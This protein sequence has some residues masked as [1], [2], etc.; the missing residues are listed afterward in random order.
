MTGAS[1]YIASWIVK[2]LLAR[3]Y[4][5]RGTV[6]DTGERPPSRSALHLPPISPPPRGS[7]LGIPYRNWRDALCDLCDDL[8]GLLALGIRELH[9]VG[10]RI[11][12]SMKILS[13]G[14][15]FFLHP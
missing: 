8:V 15:E 4:T 10:D 14:L 12:D 2:L 6:R 11:F 1:G 7:P 3:G 9:R 13:G 5:V